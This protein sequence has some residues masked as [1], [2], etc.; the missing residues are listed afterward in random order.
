MLFKWY[1]NAVTKYFE[2]IINRF[3]GYNIDSG[4]V[5][6]HVICGMRPF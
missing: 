4:L 2:D 3:E 5:I 6:N 1:I